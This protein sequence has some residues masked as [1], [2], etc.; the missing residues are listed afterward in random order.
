MSPAKT[1]AVLM[2]EMR[3]ILRDRTTFLLLLL[4]PVVLMIIFAYALAVDIREVPITLLNHDR[5]PYSRDYVVM[6]SNSKDLVMGPPAES[7]DQIEAWFDRSLTKAVIVIPPEFS[8]SLQAGQPA[9]IQLLVDGTDPTTAEFAIDHIMSRSV[10][11]GYWVMI[12]FFFSGYGVPVE[13]MPPLLQ[14][15]ANIFPIYHYMIIFR[16]ILLK[17]AGLGVIWP[18]ILAGLAIG[19]VVIPVAIWFLGR[20]QW[21]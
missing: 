15:L 3:H 20:Q 6:L 10:V 2:K 18:Q 7:Y 1:Y 16:A 4:I 8:E 17:G 14:K 21:D 12:E 11:F 9:H 5:G 19:A 13:N